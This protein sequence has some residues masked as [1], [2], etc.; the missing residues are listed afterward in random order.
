MKEGLPLDPFSNKSLLY[1]P[2][3]MPFVIYSIG[4]DGKDDAGSLEYDP[5]NGIESTGD[6]L[7]IVPAERKYPFP[8]KT[9]SFASRDEV[10]KQFPNGL[11]PDSFHKKK[12]TPLFI[13][14]TNPPRIISVGPDQDLDC[15]IKSESGEVVEFFESVYDPAN[16]INSNGDIF[17]TPGQLI[18]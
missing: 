15:S 12:G 17:F 5:T 10:L 9:K 3:K 8:L 7:N 2:E 14:E 11:P 18:E 13:T 6:I 1:I 16:G 4:P